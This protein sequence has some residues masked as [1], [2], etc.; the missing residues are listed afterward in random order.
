MIATS[1]APEY[2]LPRQNV[3]CKV[4]RPAATENIYFGFIH[5][6]VQASPLE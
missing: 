4:R 2:D 3:A 6:D 5:G 1:E